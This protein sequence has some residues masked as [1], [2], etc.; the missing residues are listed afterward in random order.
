MV[1]FSL[2]TVMV[3]VLISAMAVAQ[4]AESEPETPKVQAFGGFVFF[5]ADTPGMTGPL[6]SYALYQPPNTF[7]IRTFFQGWDAQAQYNFSRWIGVAVD[8]GGRYGSPFTV[9]DDIKGLPGGHTYSLLAGPVISYRTKSIFTPFVH[10]LFG[11]EGT[12]LEGSTIET[13]RFPV[14]SV[15]TTYYDFTMALGGGVDVRVSRRISVRPAQLEWYRTTLNQ[16]RFYMQAFGLTEYLNVGT[17]EQNYRFATG[18][19]VKF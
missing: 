3:A 11:W 13:P 14:T 7:G 18:I 12:T 19:V 4:Q 9:I 2:A 16:N 8:G 1:R 17:K 5:H 10:T 15:A 6:I